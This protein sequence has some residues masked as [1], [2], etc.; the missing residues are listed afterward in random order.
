MYVLDNK[1]TE[2]PVKNDF[3][4]ESICKVLFGMPEN[5]LETKVIYGGLVI[6]EG[7]IPVAL[8]LWPPSLPPFSGDLALLGLS[9]GLLT[10]LDRAKSRIG[11]SSK[12]GNHSSSK[13]WRALFSTGKL[14][15]S[16]TNFKN[17][18]VES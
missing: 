18:Y 3:T 6:H 2:N 1:C 16:Q 7:E 11:S 15:C 17:I 4:I 10:L 12:K 13:A 5:S 9:I 8:P 14:Q